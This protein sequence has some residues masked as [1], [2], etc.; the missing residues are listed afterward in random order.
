M[1]LLLFLSAF[2]FS[3]N[4]FAQDYAS[5]WNIVIQ[6]E[7]DG[8][9]ETANKKVLEI[10]NQAKKDKNEPQIIKCFFYISKFRQVF[11]E[12][13]QESIL[14]A[15][16]KEINEVSP[17]SKGI[18]Y[19][20]Y[21]TIL[22]DYYQY[23]EY[24]INQLTRTSEK[25]QN[26]TTWTSADFTAE[27]DLAFSKTLE[28]AITLRNK[29]ISQ[30]KDI[31][32]IPS[33]TDAKN[34]SLYEFLSKNIL[35]YYISK[36]NEW[37]KREELPND[38]KIIS[39][40]YSD[41]EKF[42]VLPLNEFSKDLQ[43]ALKILQEDEKYYATNDKS[44]LDF[45]IYNR[46]NTIKKIFNNY[47]IH[48]AAISNLTKSTNNHNLQQQ[49]KLDQVDN[50]LEESQENNPQKNIQ[51][52]A[53]LDS[54]I[55]SKAIEYIITDAQMKKQ[56]I[57]NK[58]LL[59]R[60]K[61]VLYPN[62]KSRAF[63]EFKN[64]K[65]IKFSYF[66]ID[67]KQK[68]QINKLFKK[69]TNKQ[70]KDSLFTVIQ[71]KTPFRQVTHLLPDKN[72]YAKHSTE[73]LLEK[74][75]VGH[76][77]IIT[78][79]T[80][81]D[82]DIVLN[83]NYAIIS[84]TNIDFV[85]DEN[86]KQEDY[87]LV[88]RE[89]G[90]PLNDVIIK[91][92][93]G[94][95]KT[96]T[97]GKAVLD[98]EKKAKKRIPSTIYFIR[99][100]DTLCHEYQPGIATK[101]NKKAE[102]YHN[103]QIKLYFD[104]AIYRPGQK[105]YFKAIVFQDKNHIKSIVPFLT[106]NFEVSDR[107]KTFKEFEVQTNEFGSASGEFIIPK[108]AETGT[109]EITVDEPEDNTKDNS[110]YNKK[111]D[112]HAFWNYCN[113]DNRS[114]RFLVEEYKRPTFEVVFEQLK[115]NAT[116]GDSIKITG[117]AKSLA[118]SPITEATVKY[119]ISKNISSKVK[120][121][122][123]Q[124]NYIQE[125]IKTD[126][127]GQ[128]TINFI[129]NDS[130]SKNETIE[131]I[132]FNINAEVTDSNGETRSISTKVEV[133]QKTLRLNIYIPRNGGPF[134]KF[135]K[136]DKNT[137]TI[138]STTYNNY[139]IDT[140]GTLQI[141]KKKK[142]N[143]LKNRQ[144]ESP[145]LPVIS[146]QD[147]EAL[148]PHEP[149]TSDK[150]EQDTLV[151]TL[152]FNTKIN[153][154]IE[155]TNLDKGEYSVI[156]ITKDSKNNT[157]EDTGSFEMASLIDI[158][159]DSEVFTFKRLENTSKEKIEFEFQSVL[160]QLYLT[161]RKYIGLKLTAIETIEIKNGKGYYVTSKTTEEKDIDFHFITQWENNTY[162]KTTK[163][164]KE[165]IEHKLDFEIISFRNKIEPGSNEKWSFK[166][167]NSLL[168]TEILASMY[169]TSLDQFEKTYW[170]LP[171][172][173]K[174]NSPNFFHLNYKKNN[175]QYISFN[176]GSKKIY[177]RKFNLTPEM[178]W[179][180]FDFKNSTG[181]TDYINKM[182]RLM[183]DA[184]KNGKLITGVISDHSGP[185][186]GANIVVQGT[187]RGTQSDFDGDYHIYAA[188]GEKLIYSFMGMNDII[189]TVGEE[190][191]I[192]ILMEDNQN[193]LKEVVVGAVGF[194]ISP[195]L[196]KNPNII[197]VTSNDKDLLFFKGY[198]RA[199]YEED[200]EIGIKRKLSA[201]TS[202]YSVVSNS[203]LPT[204]TSVNKDEK[205]LIVIDGEIQDLAALKQIPQDD[206]TSI[207][208]LTEKE[209]TNLYGE[210]GKNGVI[211]IGT[212]KAL[213]EL[214]NVK[215]RKNFNET[216]FFYPHLTTDTDGK[217]SFNFTTPE[218]LTKWR[219]RLFGHNK[220]AENGYFE[221]E[222]ISQKEVMVMTN[223]PRFLREND[224]IRLSAKVVNM[225][226]ETKSG[227]AVLQLY[228]AATGNLINTECHNTANSKNF[229]CKPKES[230][231]L[232]WSI[233]VPEGVQ[234]IQYK[235]AA[236]SGNFSDGEENLLPVLSNKI[237]V[238]ETLPIWVRE[239]TKKELSF[240]NFKNNDS[241]TLKNH[242]FTFE[243]TSNPAWFAL[244]SLPY[245]MEY[246]HECAEQTFARYYANFIATQI[247]N[248]NPKISE[249]FESWKKETKKSRLEMNEELK[250]LVLQETP[251]LLDAD[252]EAKNKHLAYLFDLKKLKD[253]SEE[254]T[255]KLEDKQSASGGFSW[256]EDGDD[257][258]FIT[259]H[260]LSG[261][262][263]L[264]TMFPD[265]QTSFKEITKRGI[266]YI[267]KQFALSS[268]KTK[269]DSNKHAVELQYLYTR[270]FYVKSHPI[271]EEGKK[272]IVNQLTNLKTNWL[273]YNLYQKAQLALIFNR[274]GEKDW[275]KKI[276]T[277]F[278]ETASHDTEKGMY[279][280]ANKN[281]LYWYESPIETQA[282]IIE[283]FSEIEND[284]TTV[285]AL[286]VWLIKNKQTN[287]WATTKAT[288]EAIYALLLQG[289]NWL[290]TKDNTVFKIGDDKV[291]Q[292]KLT[293]KKKE[294]N[295]GYTKL[296]W[297]A[298]EITKDMETVSIENKSEVPG[299]GGAYWQYFENLE[300]IK[301]ESKSGLSIQKEIFLK[302]KDSQGE[303]LMPI[304]NQKTVLGDI[305]TFRLIIR[306]DNDLEFV[307]LKDL[308][309]S[310]LEPVDV[311]SEYK[312]NAGLSYYKSTK[313]VAT[314][315]FFD[316]IK[317]GTYIIEYDVRVNN[318]GSFNNGIATL[319]SM[320][321]PEFSAHSTSA[322][323]K[324]TE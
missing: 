131:Y 55:N 107:S 207:T 150:T 214:E 144:F 315:F 180:G 11:E 265:S 230:T 9:T 75:P 114:F 246:E 8:K 309:A 90:K 173:Y 164:S 159:S 112:K 126:K 310:C 35:Q 172:F 32:E 170:E 113:W 94:T 291:L 62:E 322:K 110:Y 250:S 105:V 199:I 198:R 285:D 69:E 99:K 306:T 60:L 92:L 179:F 17:A 44:L 220:K 157:I 313:D 54:V 255:E 324:V 222:I 22:K 256:F 187:T 303:K 240:E 190:T 307:Q 125:E 247:I 323:I 120:G 254:I 321:A 51:A 156:A 295:T 252:E 33:F 166:V 165:E 5:D 52:M 34:Y 49:L 226:S 158:K 272:H 119:S 210:K 232:H 184:P 191:V 161:V 219:L 12:K 145:D 108:N 21:G 140:E 139:P 319:Q 275:A 91:T 273:Q 152:A 183:K 23:N 209:A 263:H 277:H 46:Y 168:E 53:I 10:Y 63:I 93:Y 56:R 284:K 97:S 19:F 245:L 298:E 7:L 294:T 78:E 134:A 206:I 73:I 271:N 6:N 215:T 237:L 122:Q 104:R 316:N 276:I 177:F 305:V 29:S 297:K 70:K 251:W 2:L 279:W 116:I 189:E 117:T 280:I 87:F 41:S 135:F 253:S 95:T 208:I 200:D 31:L 289:T 301:T 13:A 175:N 81:K 221:S 47:S 288:T 223:M 211:L 79:D 148:F 281:G 227:V 266:L 115:E 299:F 274:F 287:N 290:E 267:D 239:K 171:Y 238:T 74:L 261:I 88:E 235:I 57:L 236:K 181:S 228:D 218:S 14:T 16:R 28:N 268:Q 201:V 27:I 242:L 138:Q 304:K 96:N 101:V 42:S 308:R 233:T 102:G 129:A 314:H 130:D 89:S 128:F 269:T 124:S 30:Y 132:H 67:S 217:I 45:A 85:K 176:L 244:Q 133:S 77:F 163:I 66:K 83:K 68:I 50:I 72:D 26:F 248:S 162:Y 278:K 224:T 143:Y 64:I 36:N 225:T 195:P 259:Q 123:S 260:I 186:P 188:E 213:K 141:F 147:F 296:N 61:E 204:I 167:N 203:E 149:Y 106:L 318:Q 212:K 151:Q 202:S 243:Y 86:E 193:Q 257:N 118:G 302:V 84:V 40:F 231:P 3:F 317:K 39:G 286:K 71:S 111:E 24:K 182:K 59:I 174:T 65:S 103:A 178:N 293:E 43:N 153:R 142:K 282:L 136:E 194:K 283:A 192:N 311:I 20:I 229:S 197:V 58:E 121:Y 137:I 109:F 80:E 154:N 15:L 262:G 25:N 234:G 169:D 48:Y 292:Q 76:Y 185:I 18:L 1:R 155:I 127:N 38:K 160:P 270:S 205:A 4:A 37:K 312:Y 300:N 258:I 320:Y 98:K 146:K 264:N 241:K 249:L 196:L 216:A 82:E 100:N